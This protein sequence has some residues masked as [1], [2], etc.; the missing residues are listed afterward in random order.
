MVRLANRLGATLELPVTISWRRVPLAIT[1]PTVVNAHGHGAVVVGS[2]RIELRQ[3]TLSG[4]IYYPSRGAIREAADELLAFL[5]HPPIE[6]FKWPGDERRLF[7]WPQGVAQEWVD[8]GAEL[9]IDI[10]MVAPD[11]FWYGAQVVV[12]QPNASQWTVTVAGNAPARPAVTF[13]ITSAGSGITF[14][15]PGGVIVLEGDYLSGDVVTVDT[16]RYEAMLT[17]GAETEL[18]NDQFSDEYVA[19]GFELVPGENALMYQGPAATVTLT[20]RPRWY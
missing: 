10:P 9:V 6:V 13:S 7:A 15:G 4:S 8:A 5:Q 2:S 16:A 12:S 20:Y 11:P 1:V 3:F 17:R 19:D 18:I 14:T